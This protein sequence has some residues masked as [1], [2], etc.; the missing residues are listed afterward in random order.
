VKLSVVFSQT[1][2][3]NYNRPQAEGGFSDQ[4]IF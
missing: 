4:T 3:K 1:F 2:V